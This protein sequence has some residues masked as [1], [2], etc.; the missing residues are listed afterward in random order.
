MLIG[1]PDAPVKSSVNTGV[2]PAGGGGAEA[3]ASVNAA[4]IATSGA[5]TATEAAAMRRIRDGFMVACL[6]CQGS[7]ERSHDNAGSSI[8]QVLGTPVPPPREVP[9]PVGAIT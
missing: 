2:H 6:H 8:C 5:A 3:C 4:T 9:A 7:R 1:V